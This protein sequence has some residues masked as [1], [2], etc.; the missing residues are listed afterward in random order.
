MDQSFDSL[1]GCNNSSDDLDLDDSLLVSPAPKQQR[2]SNGRRFGGS[3]AANKRSGSSSSSSDPNE[4]YL[5]AN[6]TPVK[7][8]FNYAS[9]MEE[10]ECLAPTPAT[11]KNQQSRRGST[12][13]VN[14]SASPGSGRVGSLFDDAQEE[15]I[16][17]EEEEVVEVEVT[18]VA[19]AAIAAGAAALAA[20]AARR[21]CARA[22]TTNCCT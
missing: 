10:L 1:A 17:K 11:N 16:E 20:A 18:A 19:V 15:G 14:A 3:N 9:A 6:A 5:D 7:T 22:S 4:S 21:W 8:K 2:S 13:F 12:L